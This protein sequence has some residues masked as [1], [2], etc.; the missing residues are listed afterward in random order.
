MF[1]EKPTCEELEKKIRTLEEDLKEKKRIEDEMQGELT[2]YRTIVEEAQDVIYE[3]T[4]DG[5]ITSLNQAFETVTGFSRDDFIGKSFAP[6]IHPDDLKLSEK[7]FRRGLQGETLPAHEI[8]FVAKSGETLTGEIVEVPQIHQGKLFSL[9][10]IIRNVTQRK[11][12]EEALRVNEERYRT[13]IES[14]K[15]AVHLID[16]DQCLVLFNKRMS[17]WF[18]QLGI[19]QN[20]VGRPLQEVCPFL[21]EEVFNQYRQVLE[22][23]KT[24]STQEETEINGQ[25][26]I[27]ETHKIPIMDRDKVRNIL[28][29]V[30]DITE[31]KQ[32]TDNLRKSEER[33]RLINNSTSDSLYSYDRT[34]RLTFANKA[35]CKTLNLTEDQIIGKTHAELGFDDLRCR[36][37]DE[38][39]RQVYET[40][41]TITAETSAPIPGG[42]V[43]DYEVV[44]NPL[45]NNKGEL[46]GISGMTRDITERK[47]AEEALKASEVKLSNALRIGKLGHWEYD[48]ANDM[49]IFSDEFYAIFRTTAEQ[50]GGYSMSSARYTELFVHPEERLVVAA[51]DQKAIET[52]DPEYSQ[53]LEHR[54]TYADG[55]IGHISVQIKVLKDSKNITIRTFGVN[56]DI[57]ERVKKEAALRESEER[58]RVLFEDNMNS[59][60]ILKDRIIQYVNQATIETFGYTKEEMIGK[61]TLFLH[62]SPKHYKDAGSMLSESLKTKSK[63]TREWP[64]KKKDGETLWI[65]VNTSKL[66]GDLVVSIMHDITERKQLE[67][68]RSK[69]A[70]LESIGLLAGGIAHDFNNILG[71]ILGNISIANMLA[72]K[73]KSAVSESLTAAQAACSRAR[74]LTQQLLTFAKG[75]APAKKTTSISGLIIEASGFS[76]RGSNSKCRHYTPEDLWLCE[77]D[78]GQICQVINNLI[79]NANQAMPEGGTI[80]IYA[81]NVTVGK[82]NRLPLNKGRYVKL[83]IKDQ[84]IGISQEHL[85]KIFDPYFTTKQTGS[86]LGLATTF[87]IIKRHDGYITV[88]SELMV[89]TTFHIYLPASREHVEKKEKK[90]NKITV[91]RGKILVMDDEP[92]LC[93]LVLRILEKEGHKVECADNGAQAI[94]M[95]VKAK[96]SGRPFD[97]LILDLTIPG[98]IGGKETIERLTE[99]DPSVKAIVASGYSNDPVVSNFKDYGFSA[100][101]SKPYGLEDLL[102]V[103]QIVMQE[104]KG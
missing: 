75:G 95:Y 41:R 21:S 40:G 78:E 52:N 68:E 32:A 102:K 48:I 49:F 55:E 71:V 64:L 10:G 44:L 80:S 58:F 51:E 92:T 28:T 45:N 6:L 50:M 103:V 43:R 15:D 27:T 76:L 62:L 94:E 23:A 31:N 25:L 36:E 7:M 66:P 35:L 5:K 73:E 20:A 63:W 90:K 22:T 56:Q 30:S 53:Q 13:T 87:S 74:S 88:E 104:K 29:I 93:N 65:E 99:I 2:R 100:A 72:K 17:L 81:E 83:T 37:W 85:S 1:R 47:Q 18:E 79:I 9:I 12:A 96:N 54:A 89:G 57:T 77:V 34:G 98:G 4:L 82:E 97:A 11:Q 59:I 61:S 84:G 24:I 46:V 60:I 8:R 26:Y 16:R 70:K 42:V 14:L 39:H 69:A 3:H 67:E 38:L 101:I 33:L 19:S 91:K 86:G